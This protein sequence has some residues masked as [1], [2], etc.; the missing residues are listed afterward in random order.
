MTSVEWKLWLDSGTLSQVGK[1]HAFDEDTGKTMCGRE[2]PR[3]AEADYGS[4]SINCKACQKA[5]A[6]RDL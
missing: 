3:N 5:I 2:V 6:K 1:S 4:F